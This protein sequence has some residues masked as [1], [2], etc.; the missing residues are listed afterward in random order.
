MTFIL[1]LYFHSI[2]FIKFYEKEF[3]KFSVPLFAYTL[4]LFIK[5]SES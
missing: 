2:W 4:H 5:N 1:K 3:H